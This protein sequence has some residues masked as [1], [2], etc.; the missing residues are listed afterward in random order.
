M[1]WWS[2]PTVVLGVSNI[3]TVWFILSQNNSMSFINAA[4]ITSL[5]VFDIFTDHIAW[6]PK[7]KTNT[8]NVLQE[9]RI[10]ACSMSFS[11]TFWNSGSHFFRKISFRAVLQIMKLCL[12]AWDTWIFCFCKKYVL[13]QNSRYARSLNIT[14]DYTCS[15][16]ALIL[17]VVNLV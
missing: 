16:I 1:R 9:L 5:Q 4:T 10:Q 12:T 7:Y 13:A 8:E 11:R 17:S 6:Y 15:F 14:M 3:S 2:L